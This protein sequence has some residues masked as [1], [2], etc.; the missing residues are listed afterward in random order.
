MHEIVRTDE[1][2]HNPYRNWEPS[3]T[4]IMD[5]GWCGKLIQHVAGLK[6][7]SS[8]GYYVPDPFAI[9]SVGER[10]EE[11]LGHSKNIHW[12]PIDPA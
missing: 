12:C 2:E 10:D 8:S 7:A 9:P 4:G 6:L 1:P 5:D 11:S 3:P